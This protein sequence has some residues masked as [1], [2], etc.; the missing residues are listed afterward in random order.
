MPAL[1]KVT[2]SPDLALHIATLNSVRETFTKAHTSEKNKIAIKK[3]IRQTQERY[4]IGK[5]VYHKRDADEK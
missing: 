5:D 1:D 4:E 2:T 3:Q